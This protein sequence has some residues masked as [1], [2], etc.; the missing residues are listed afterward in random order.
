MRT[1]RK[2]AH[3]YWNYQNPEHWQHQMLVWGCGATGSL[4][5]R[6]W[7]CKW[8]SHLWGHLVV[9]TKLNIL[10]SYDPAIMLP[11]I[12]SK[13][14]KIYVHT[15]PCTQMY[16]AAVFITANTCKQPRRP[17]VVE[18]INTL[19]SIQTVEFYFTKRNEPLSHE[20][21]WRNLKAY[22]WVKETSLQRLLS[23]SKLYD[24]LEMA[25]LWR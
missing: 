5:H 21:T 14:L 13:E 15:K 17:S 20:K 22:Y 8:Y 1:R 6:Q 18:W 3:T 25:R 23:D 12:Y 11:Y 16:I 9:F 24:I 2:I 10:L 19:W 7:K 4:I